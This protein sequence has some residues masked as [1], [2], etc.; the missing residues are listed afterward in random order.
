MKVVNAKAASPSGA[1]SA[2]GASSTRVGRARSSARTAMATSLCARPGAGSA[3]TVRLVGYIGT[4][5]FTY[6]NLVIPARARLQHPKTRAQIR[7]LRREVV[8]VI[9]EDLRAV[10][11]DVH[12]ILEAAAAVAVAVEARLDRDHVAR[13]ELAGASAESRLLVYLE[14]DAV[15]ERVVEAVPEHLA[16]LLGQKR[17][18]AVLLEDVAGE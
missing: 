8:R 10:L 17:R 16:G 18:E 15:A 11:G 14:P 5:Y 4:R 12:E 7:A 13:D 9:G 6:S 3:E 1:G 2:T